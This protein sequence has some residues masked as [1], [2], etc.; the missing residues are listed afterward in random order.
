MSATDGRY[1][2]PVCL[3]V[4]G[5]RCVVVGGGKVGA[6][7]AA[8]LAAAGAEVVV[9]AER[10]GTEVVAM[11]EQGAIRLVHRRFEAGDLTGAFLAVAATGDGPADAAVAG[12]ARERGIL[13]NAAAR[14]RGDLSLPAVIR[15][16]PLT[17]SISTGGAAPALAAVLRRRLEP[18][19]D[20][21]YGDLV[22]LAGSARGRLRGRGNAKRWRR[23]LDPRILGLLAC[24]RH[25][26]A[27]ERIEAALRPGQQDGFVSLV[28]AGPGDPGLLTLAGWDRLS[29]ADVVVYDRLADP[30]LLDLA[31]S[32]AER[33]YIGK[34]YGRHVLEQEELNRL[35]V[36]LGRLGRRVVRLKGGDPF[37]YGRGGEEADALAA[38]GIPFD[39]VPGVSSAVAVPAYAGIP[40]TDRRFAS[41][42][43]V[44]TGHQ[45][46]A[47]PRCGIDWAG[48]ATAAGTLV[49]LMGVHR[50]DA[51]V[52]AL[53]GHGRDPSTPAAIVERGATPRQRTIEATLGTLP[54][55]AR[56]AGIES[57]SVVVVGEVVRLRARLQWFHPDAGAE[58]APADPAGA[59][60]WP[61][62]EIALPPRPASGSAVDA[63]VTGP[64]Q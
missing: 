63:A 46:P 52:A 19:I 56:A 29:R 57:P 3:D 26:E 17:V 60:G 44:V 31:P 21:E 39:V 2:Y 28:G 13:L 61:G 1:A 40:V 43:A 8:G 4:R 10:P 6:E 18:L 45:D 41:S 22:E 53:I 51:I 62:P 59:A 38:A 54:G 5:R 33:I 36:A 55:A 15:R 23:V 58:H 12:E 37:V 11:A 24:G 50:L 27:N 14:G 9:V 47:D 48:L 49:I 64:R 42:V 7:R 25:A 20:P 35:L 32:D 30:A 34:A 16:G